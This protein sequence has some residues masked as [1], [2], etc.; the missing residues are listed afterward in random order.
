M[1]GARVKE[2]RQYLMMGESGDKNQI[3]SS[4]PNTKNYN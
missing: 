3:V 4:G 2:I 1:E